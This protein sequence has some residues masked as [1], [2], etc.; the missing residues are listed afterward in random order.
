MTSSERGLVS[1]PEDLS[2]EDLGRF[3]TLNG[4]DLALVK[5]QRGDHNR[6]G[7]ALQLCTLRYLGFI[8]DTLLQPPED[9]LRLLAQQLDASVSVLKLYGEREQTRSDHLLQV[10]KTLGYR[11]SLPLD[12]V[13]LE[14]W[15][16]ERAL[17]HDTPTFLL[18][19]L[20]EQFR[21]QRIVRPGLTSLERIVAT[22]SRTR[23]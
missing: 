14:R 5:Q 17:E 3:F 15:L 16:T 20:C 8:P 11:Y 7:F 21:W 12:L 22:S 13:E 23:S 19:L 2:H 4:S 9:V 10:M 1:Y 18:Q 6:L